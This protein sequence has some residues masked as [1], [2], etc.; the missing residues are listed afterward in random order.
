M[1]DPEEPDEPEEEPDD[2]DP[3]DDDPDDEPDPEVPLEVE[4][5]PDDVPEEALEVP[6]PLE[7]P[8]E[9]VDAPDVVDD[10]EELLAELEEVSE[11]GVAGA[12]EGLGITATAGLAEAVIVVFVPPHPVIAKTAMVR[13]PI[14]PNPFRLNCIRGP[15]CRGGSR[16]SGQ[17]RGASTLDVY[18]ELPKRIKELT[19]ERTG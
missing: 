8:V 13:I 3:E 11:E 9:E 2:E 19:L 6:E 5:E 4:E 16:Q 15:F 18:G 12:L 14:A 17:V 1:P 10:P 7:E